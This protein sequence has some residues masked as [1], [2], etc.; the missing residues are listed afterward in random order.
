[1]STGDQYGS[2]KNSYWIPNLDIH[3]KVIT[4][5][6]QFYLGPESSVR[7]YTREG[8]DGFLITTPGDCLTDEQIDDICRKSKEHWEKQAAQYKTDSGKQLKRPLHRPVVV[9]RSNKHRVE[10]V[11]N[12][13]N[14]ASRFHKIN[15]GP[16]SDKEG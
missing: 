8:S 12:A 3:K 5:E 2:E 9:S 1:M 14:R 10:K 13:D 16:Q 11:K 6:L 7:P 4:Q 15:R